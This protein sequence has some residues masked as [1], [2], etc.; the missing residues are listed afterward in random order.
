MLKTVFSIWKFSVCR[1]CRPQREPSTNQYLACAGSWSLLSAQR[2][3]LLAAL[4]AHGWLVCQ[5]SWYPPQPLQHL[6]SWMGRV[7]VE[8]Q[9]VAKNNWITFFLITLL[10]LIPRRWWIFCIQIGS[11]IEN[12]IPC[13]VK[14]ILV[15]SMNGCGSAAGR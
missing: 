11:A 7:N 14:C 12:K 2:N 4:E 6:N 5:G 8:E 13:R 10:T 9:T 15:R 1:F 3:G